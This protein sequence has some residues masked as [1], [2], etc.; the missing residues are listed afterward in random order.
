MAKQ[1]NFQPSKHP[2]LPDG[3]ERKDA[4][5]QDQAAE[6]VDSATRNTRIP[7]AHWLCLAL[8]VVVLIASWQ[9]WGGPTLPKVGGGLVI[10]WAVAQWFMGGGMVVPL[11]SACLGMAAISL[12]LA[13]AP[14]L[15]GLMK[16]AGTKVVKRRRST[17][18]Y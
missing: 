4:S 10:A 12:H 14:L 16:Q 15:A 18:S 11:I 2:T 3:Y 8:G 7:L 1:F 9:Q 13:W 17:R 6:V 5:A